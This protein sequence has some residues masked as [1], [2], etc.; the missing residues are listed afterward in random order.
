MCLN[1]IS[2]SSADN[3][4]LTFLIVIKKSGDNFFNKLNNLK[5]KKENEIN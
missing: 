3:S 2:H 1:F 4:L 5:T